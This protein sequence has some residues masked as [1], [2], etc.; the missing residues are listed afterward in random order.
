MSENPDELKGNNNFSD[1][2]Q[3]LEKTEIIND[4]VKSE[5]LM[6]D[7]IPQQ[8]SKG[9][10]KIS[11]YGL[12]I[13]YLLPLF[14]FQIVTGNGFWL[15]V[16]LGILLEFKRFKI[17]R[18]LRT[19]IAKIVFFT[20]GVKIIEMEGYDSADII[21]FWWLLPIGGT[22][23]ALITIFSFYSFVFILPLFLILYKRKDY[24]RIVFYVTT[25]PRRSMLYLRTIEEKDKHDAMMKMYTEGN[26][27]Y[28]QFIRPT[29]IGHLVSYLLI[30]FI[31]IMLGLLLIPL[32]FVENSAVVNQMTQLS[33]LF[34][35]I[36][37]ISIISYVL[38]TTPIRGFI[39][40]RWVTTK[41]AKFLV[42]NMA[43]TK[44]NAVPL[45]SGE[46]YVE[47][48]AE[49]LDMQSAT[50]FFTIFGS[51]RAFSIFIIPI[52]IISL[53]L[54]YTIFDVNGS[55]SATNTV[56]QES[57]L[58]T[59]RNLMAANSIIYFLA[60]FI[61][62]PILIAAILPLIFVLS[63]AEIKR[64]TWDA[65]KG[66]N[67]IHNVENLGKT[68]SNVIK[69]VIGIGS[70]TSLAST[71]SLAVGKSSAE[72][73]YLITAIILIYGTVLII[74][75]TLFLV[76]RYLASGEHALGVNYLRYYISSSNKVGVGTISKNY[77]L[78]NSLMDP[79][80]EIAEK[81]GVLE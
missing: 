9:F 68:L 81:I 72:N 58:L 64:A 28:L 22:L 62:I 3:S 33:I 34:I 1:S 45:F 66:E 56:N 31:P 79:P 15:L 70:I 18:S 24:L 25:L 19:I 59:F 57:I 12:L 40:V 30:I 51:G 38:L 49:I 77:T 4:V 69:L 11:S 39:F 73:A 60:I 67:E 6:D 54:R 47:E 32:T 55:V 29:T 14:L 80:K 7:E 75:G 71:I 16:F 53:L 42:T 43:G 63:D 17:I 50:S 36:G 8:F 20:F 65:E 37:I 27:Q 41:L 10:I 23:T 74:P 13:F 35:L 5:P 78:N 61:F 21:R 48:K 46:Y 26:R 2:E 52:A 76:Y 44:L